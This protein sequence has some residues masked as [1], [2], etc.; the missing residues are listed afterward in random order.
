MLPLWELERCFAEVTSRRDAPDESVER[1]VTA[2]P[3]LTARERLQI[4][5]EGYFARLTECLADD[6]PALAHALGEP[7]FEQL[8]F[9]YIASHRSRSPSLNRY[10]AAMADHCR[11]RT[12]PWAPFAADLARLEW[13]LVE[14]VH[15]PVG[16]SLPQNA[17]SHVT[18]DKLA[19]ARLVPSPALRV[20][21]CDYPVN[22]YY[23]A[24][25]E[26]L[27]PALPERAATGVA[28]YR[29]GLTLWRVDLE[30]RAAALLAD[31]ASGR[32]LEQALIAAAAR[33]SAGEAVL[34]LVQQLPR[35]LESWVR[36]GFFQGIELG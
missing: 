26:E 34:D 7:A 29:S 11:S 28:V 24:F 16:Q 3:K 21:L 6:Y 23:R 9:D 14:I 12:E 32:S 18:P 30:P 15:E 31:L 4:Y 19:S 27:R 25:R 20:L 13:A 5:Q 2:G 17:L 22:A 8:C 35:W 33:M 36:D 10:G 1:L